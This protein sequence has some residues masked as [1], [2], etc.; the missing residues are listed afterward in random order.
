M[1][2]SLAALLRDE[3]GVTAIEYGVIAAVVAALVVPAVS[4]LGASVAEA[5]AELS[6]GLAPSDGPAIRLL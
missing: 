1:S 6:A 4:V 5:L 2:Q 3:T